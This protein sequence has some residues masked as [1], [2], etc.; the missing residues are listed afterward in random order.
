MKLRTAVVAAVALAGVAVASAATAP[1]AS[2]AT[3]ESVIEGSLGS[4]GGLESAL[5]LTGRAPKA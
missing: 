4:Y 5:K 2:A 3:W 1:A